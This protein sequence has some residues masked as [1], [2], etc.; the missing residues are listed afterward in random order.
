MGDIEEWDSFFIFLI[1]F[2]RKFKDKTAYEL[3]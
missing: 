2:K 3:S 1:L